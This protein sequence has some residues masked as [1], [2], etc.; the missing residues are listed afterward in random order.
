MVRNYPLYKEM[1]TV[2]RQIEQAERAGDIA[3]AAQLGAELYR[4][5]KRVQARS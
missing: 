3:K 4:L 5:K 1:D 2:K